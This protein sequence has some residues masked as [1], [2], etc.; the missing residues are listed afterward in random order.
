MAKVNR[1]DPLRIAAGDWNTALDAAAAYRRTSGPGPVGS[2]L[3]DQIGPAV[4]V[5]IENQTGAA[6][7]AGDCCK[8]GDAAVT[9][10][11]TFAGRPCFQGLDVTAD[12]DGFT[13]AAEPIAAGAVGRAVIQGVAVARVDFA[14]VGHAFAGPAA[15][16][17]ALA[18]G[19]WG[20]ARVLSSPPGTG[21]QSVAVLLS[22]GPAAEGSAAADFLSGGVFVAGAGAPLTITAATPTFDVVT[23]T[24]S[25]DV[26]GFVVGGNAGELVIPAAGFYLLTA[27]G[28]MNVNAGSIASFAAGQTFLLEYDGATQVTFHGYDFTLPPSATVGDG[29]T[30]SLARTVFLL[31][32]RKIRVGI[33]AVPAGASVEIA[34]SNVYLTATRL[35]YADGAGGGGGGGVGTLPD[36]GVTPGTYTNA[37][38]TVDSKGRLTAASSGTGGGAGGASSF[39]GLLWGNT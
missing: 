38:L 37:T 10:D 27:T 31:S 33:G 25:H 9:V 20:P 36:T 26:G 12:T 15:G 6:L 18:S 39:D 28:Q 1:G 2:P 11:R 8:V 19:D 14:D 22:G 23:N 30:F 17:T 16:E 3:A 7:A 35:D 32:G 4:E 29:A 24:V 5:L 34:P 13:V 21:V